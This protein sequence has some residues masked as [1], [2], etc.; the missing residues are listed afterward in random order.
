MK[1][2]QKVKKLF[3][4]EILSRIFFSELTNREIC[5]TFLQHALHDPIS[6][7]IGKSII[8]CVSQNHASKITQIL[9]QLADKLYPGKYNSDFATQITSNIPGAQENSINFANNNLN[10]HTRFLDGYKSV[11]HVLCH[12]GYDD[13]RL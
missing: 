6:G 11:K 8:F 12:S 10:G 7:E 5:Q 3:F 4:N 1:R 2:G 9:N 13:Y